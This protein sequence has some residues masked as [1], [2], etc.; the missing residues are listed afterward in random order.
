MSGFASVLA[1]ATQPWTPSSIPTSTV[2]SSI[3][4]THLS[5]IEATISSCYEQIQTQT[6]YISLASISQAYRG[7]QASL[8]IIQAQDVIATATNSQELS[9]A[10]QTIF[11]NTINLQALA[12]DENLYGFYLKRAPNLI[13]LVIFSICFFYTLAMLYKSRYHWYNICFIAGLGLEFAGFL[14]RVLSF[15][16]TT[17]MNIFLLQYVSLTIAP[18]FLMGG[19]YF[20]F[21]QMVVIHGRKYSVLK[22]MWYSYLFIAS[23][24]LSLLVQA[25]GGG[26]ASIA[27]QRHQNT[28]PGRDTMIAGIVFQVVAMTIFLGFWFEFLNRI[29]FLKARQNPDDDS[30]TVKPSFGNFLKFLFNAKSVQDYRNNV[31]DGYY[32]K[33]F[34]AIRQ[35]KL[36]YYAPLAITTSVV[37]IY[38]RC[39]YRVVELSEGWKGYLISHE[40]YLM[41]LDALM[42]AITGLIF[43]PFHPVHVLGVNNV[44]KLATIKKNKDED[45]EDEEKQAINEEDGGAYEEEEEEEGN[46]HELT[47]HELDEQKNDD[48]DVYHHT[49]SDSSASPN[50]S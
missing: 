16:N 18:A 23:D 35:R 37:V 29:Y 31:L 39:V 15:N 44:V 5:N 34:S 46:S 50:Y 9:L 1:K 42:I 4:P 10:T 36:F 27:S 43:I 48:L 28:K 14:G 33:K 21:A 25:A 47:K 2:L 30:F 49:K 8:A 26:Q 3:D 6:N 32:N 20:L 7:A 40:V 41:V 11:N 24:V 12:L 19:I 13:Y 17:D 45:D 22:P 38:I